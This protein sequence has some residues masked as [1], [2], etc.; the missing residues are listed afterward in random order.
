MTCKHNEIPEVVYQPKKTNLI[1]EKTRNFLE[2]KPDKLSD[3]FL[4]IIRKIEIL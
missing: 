3:N 1:S 2:L 4:K